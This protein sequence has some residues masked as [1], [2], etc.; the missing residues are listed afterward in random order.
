MN[1]SISA[2]SFSSKDNQSWG[3]DKDVE[4][5]D[6]SGDSD[7]TKVKTVLKIIKFHY[8]KVPTG[9]GVGVRL[10]VAVLITL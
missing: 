4:N 2:K 5:S 8:Y 7:E 6:D 1:S 10:I 3:K 9:S